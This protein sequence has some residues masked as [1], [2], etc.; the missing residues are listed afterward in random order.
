MMGNEVLFIGKMGKSLRSLANKETAEIYTANNLALMNDTLVNGGLQELAIQQNP[1]PIIWIIRKDSALLSCSYYPEEEVCA[2]SQHVTAGT[3][4]SVAVIP[5]LDRDE[6]WLSVRRTVNDIAGVPTSYRYI[7]RL[8]KLGTEDDGVASSW[9]LDSAGVLSTPRQNITSIA[10]T[11]FTVGTTNHPLISIEATVTSSLDAGDFV[12]VSNTGI[13]QLD[14]KD[15]KVKSQP[16][17]THV[18]VYGSLT[19]LA[20]TGYYQKKTRRVTGITWLRGQTVGC[21]GDGAALPNTTV[22][23]L[24]A[25]I[26]IQQAASNI[27]VGLPYTSRMVSMRLETSGN[28]TNTSQAHMKRIHEVA[29]RFYNTVGGKV[30][31]DSNLTQVNTMNF[32]NTDMQMDEPVDL[33]TGDKLIR[34]TAGYNRDARVVVE[35]DQCLPMTVLAIIEHSTTNN[36]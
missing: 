10:T 29:V 4:E 19:T 11:H 21:L 34:L 26:N 9:Y 23:T 25:F 8:Q 15:F 31:A 2:W 24:G 1:Y 27:I 16:D 6:L 7:E 28:R 12:H 20:A 17:G 35:H 5:G 32:R 30:G 36:M 3:W 14:E 18:L 22:N 33:Y 13:S